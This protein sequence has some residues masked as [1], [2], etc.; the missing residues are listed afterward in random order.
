MKKTMIAFALMSMLGGCMALPVPV[1]MASF[2]LDGISM[3]ATEKSLT[4]HGL[5][6]LADQDCAVWRGFTEGEICQT[7]T[8]GDD[9]AFTLSE[10]GGTVNPGA[11][12]HGKTEQGSP[13][14]LLETAM[15]DAEPR[16]QGFELPPGMARPVLMPY[17][18]IM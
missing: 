1:Q 10:V 2:A 15:A 3:I 18:Q 7:T 12:I 11:D 4:D 17:L 14:P 9:D 13:P 6:L 8:D 16:G 5:S